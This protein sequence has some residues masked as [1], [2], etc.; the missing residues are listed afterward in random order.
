[1]AA[2]RTGTNQRFFFFAGVSFFTI[3]RTSFFR[4]D[5]LAAF[6]GA[7]LPFAHPPTLFGAF[8]FAA[9]FG[10]GFLGAGFLGAGYLGA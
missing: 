3:L 2:K 1:M 8:F 5:F 9:F 4:P 10:A 7:F 6:F